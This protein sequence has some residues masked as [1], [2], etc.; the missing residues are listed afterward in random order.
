[1]MLCSLLVF[2]IAINEAAAESFS[3]VAEAR[4][5]ATTTYLLLRR[6]Y[7]QWAMSDTT[8][9]SPDDRALGRQ[10]QA[11]CAEHAS[12]WCA[13]WDSSAARCWVREDCDLSKVGA[14]DAAVYMKVATPWRL[15]GADFAGNVLSAAGDAEAGGIYAMSRSPLTGISVQTDSPMKLSLTASPAHHANLT[16]GFSLEHLGSGSWMIHGESPSVHR[17]ARNVSLHI[18][19]PTEASQTTCLEEA[20]HDAKL[21]CG[22][23]KVLVDN[24]IQSSYKTCGGY[25]ASVG[26]TCAAAR[27]GKSEVCE[28]EHTLDC[29]VFIPYDMICQCGAALPHVMAVFDGQ[30]VLLGKANEEAMH[31]QIALTGPNSSVAVQEV[32]PQPFF[33]RVTSTTYRALVGKN[34][35]DPNAKELAKHS[36]SNV[37]AQ[38]CQEMCTQDPE[39]DCVTWGSGGEL[40]EAQAPENVHRCWMRAECYPHGVVN[41]SIDEGYNV[42]MKDRVQWRRMGTAFS[43]NVFSKSSAYVGG[44][45]AISADSVTSITVRL[46]SLSMVGLTSS[47]DPGTGLDSAFC[48]S[49]SE[50][51]TEHSQVPCRYSSNGTV[52]LGIR[53]R[54][55]FAWLEGQELSLGAASRDALHAKL[56]LL[57]SGSSAEVLEAI[58]SPGP[59]EEKPE[60]QSRRT[61]WFNYG[62]PLVGVGLVCCMIA[63]GVY[64]GP[65]RRTK[66]SGECTGH[67][68]EED[69]ESCQGSPP[70]GRSVDMPSLSNEE[71]AKDPAWAA[72]SLEQLNDL[73]ETAKE[74]LGSSYR[75]ATMYDVNRAVLQPLCE[76]HGKSYS[77]IV[78]SS[79][80]GSGFLRLTVFISHAWAENFDMFV[81][82]IND[83]FR[84]WAIKPNLWICA[85][86][87]VQ[88]TDP[89]IISMQVGTGADPSNAPF[90]RALAQA[91]KLLIVRNDAV[92]LY[93]R[94][95]C[96]WE[97]FVA[98]EQGLVHRPGCLMVAG[99]AAAPGKPVDIAGAKASNHEDKRKIL[100]HVLSGHLYQVINERLTE[101]KYYGGSA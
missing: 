91:E 57:G 71:K 68:C 89:N 81:C 41:S 78:N 70:Q 86:A 21:Q 61:S 19:W 12:C 7:G 82:S 48:I 63:L 22:D 101:I 46:T 76:A 58:S 25:C 45:Y 66:D 51:Q 37:T 28:E 3:T 26:R 18:R 69:L 20:W 32:M 52:T 2:A 16:D 60:A 1:M 47:A 54:K 67:Q 29:D 92:D 53:D 42:Y 40:L 62:L 85:T 50:P 15:V 72:I 94:I 11:L 27:K 49:S 31:V 65:R 98:Y 35:H 17:Q 74:A 100:V 95:W 36:R 13:G 75:T 77:H 56:V 99:P 55:V 87:L 84:T 80:D 4:T 59:A 88:T 5:N 6:T 44:A 43:D 33:G 9:I 34:A 10:C 39:C 38:Q 8:F 24:S 30:Q 93:D 79:R 64:C 97:L 73:R 96:C 23:C 90:T 14:G 83:A